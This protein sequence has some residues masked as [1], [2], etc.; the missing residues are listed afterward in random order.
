[1]VQ[2]YHR[3]VDINSATGQAWKSRR[4]ADGF[5]MMHLVGIVMTHGDQ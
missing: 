4:A 2:S 3:N 1:M 5:F